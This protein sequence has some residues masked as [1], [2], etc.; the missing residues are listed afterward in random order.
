MTNKQEALDQALITLT[1][2][3]TSATESHIK[4]EAAR[5]VLDHAR[6]TTDN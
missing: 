3:M 4:L 2:L 5:V 6:Q 1:E